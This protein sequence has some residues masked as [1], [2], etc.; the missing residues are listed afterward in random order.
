MAGPTLSTRPIHVWLA[1]SGLQ[2]L[3]CN[4]WLAIYL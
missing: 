4:V 2:S 1:I 3:T